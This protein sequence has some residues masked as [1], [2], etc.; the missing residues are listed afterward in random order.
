[1]IFIIL[2]QTAST[3]KILQNKV[4]NRQLIMK[5]KRKKGDPGLKL[6]NKNMG[7]T[8]AQ[9]IINISLY[10]LSLI[11]TVYMAKIVFYK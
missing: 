9:I 7:T 2:R 1:M 6:L 11:V 4:P 3:V 10:S 5:L 8:T